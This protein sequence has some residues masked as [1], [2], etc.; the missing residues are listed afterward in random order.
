MK[1]RGTILLHHLL[2][3]HMKLYQLN[4]E[5]LYMYIRKHL[6]Y[7]NDMKI[8]FPIVLFIKVPN[9]LTFMKNIRLSMFYLDKKIVQAMLEKCHINCYVLYMYIE[10]SNKQICTSPVKFQILNI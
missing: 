1:K 3:L 2:D 5:I 4:I 6:Y 7:Y 8:I 10:M 9:D